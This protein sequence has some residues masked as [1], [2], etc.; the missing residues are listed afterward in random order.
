MKRS[1][2]VLLVIVVAAVALTVTVAEIL[3]T[4]QQR[5]DQCSSTSTS[6]ITMFG[7]LTLPS[8]SGDSNLTLTVINGSCFPVDR[9]AVSSVLPTIAGVTNSSFVQFNGS[10][11]SVASPL[12]AGQLGTGSLSVGGISSTQRYD[13]SV[14]VGFASGLA[15]QV[16]TIEVYPQT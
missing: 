6:E 1:M 11:I 13:F 12:P 14:S 5:S 9:I 8:G 15:T 16:E 4:N 7:R 2:I 3:V 10:V